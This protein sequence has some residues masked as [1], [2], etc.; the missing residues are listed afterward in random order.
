MQAFPD[1]VRQAKHH[2]SG[3]CRDRCWQREFM[4]LRTTHRMMTTLTLA[5]HNIGLCWF[6]VPHKSPQQVMIE[7]TNSNNLPKT[8]GVYNQKLSCLSLVPWFHCSSHMCMLALNTGS[9][10]DPSCELHQSLAPSHRMAKKQRFVSLS[11]W[12]R[13]S[14]AHA[15]FYIILQHGWFANFYSA[16][17]GL[18]GILYDHRLLTQDSRR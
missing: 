10:I 3:E 6:S 18:F 2:L 11:P 4:C 1:S 16:I 5:E 9:K 13:F 15:P 17:A 14:L 8:E 7:T 12:Q